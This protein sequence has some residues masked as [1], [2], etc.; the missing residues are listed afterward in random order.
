M[1]D[2][3]NTSLQTPNNLLVVCGPTASG[4]SSLA[5]KLA[6]ELNG[7]IVNIDS[8]QLYKDFDIGSGKTLEKDQQ[9][10]AHHLID[11]RS[12]DQPIDVALFNEL[13]NEAITKIRAAQKLPIL[14]GGTSLY[15]KSLFHGLVDL[16]PQNIDLRKELEAQSSEQLY[17]KLKEVDLSSWHRI[18]SKDKLRMVRALEVFHLTGKAISEIQEEHKFAEHKYEALFLAL[19]WPRKVLYER[20]N[21]RCAWMLS[22][23]LI[24]ETVEIVKKYGREIMPLKSLG[25]AQVLSYIDGAIR[26]E[27]LHKEIA[28]QTRQFAKRQLTFWRN[29]PA[30]LGWSILPDQKINESANNDF[31]TLSLDF[32]SLLNDTK[33]AISQTRGVNQLLY[34]EALPLL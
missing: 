12:P 6:K 34:L 10:I 1:I 15:V 16:P 2:K 14:V 3:V 11:I 13:A 8:V 29:Q 24:E 4:K 25:Y 23:G 32:N 17:A 31:R 9:G 33:Q 30:K 7:E 27:D 26:K 21:E 5:I 19:C 18:S 20:I 28:T 22:Q